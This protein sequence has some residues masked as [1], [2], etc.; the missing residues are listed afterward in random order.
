MIYKIIRSPDNLN[1]KISLEFIFLTKLF[2]AMKE[3][4]KLKLLQF[5]SMVL[6]PSWLEI[7]PGTHNR[8]IN[9]NS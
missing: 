5:K 2:T 3:L 9:E 8:I 4:N 1:E 6:K 7:S